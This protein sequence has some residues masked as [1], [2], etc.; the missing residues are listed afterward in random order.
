MIEDR[1]DYFIF[2]YDSPN[3]SAAAAKVPMSPQGFTKM[4]HNLERDLGVKLFESDARGVRHPTRYADVF[5]KYAKNMQD[6][7]RILNNRFTQIEHENAT[8]IRVACAVGIPGFL[9]IEKITDYHD[10]NNNVTVKFTEL[11]DTLCD[12][13]VKEGRYDLAI[14][15]QPV[16][17][18][19][20]TRNL[21]SAKYMMWVKKR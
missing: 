20:T 17:P 12:S 15:L 13:L 14:T 4:I 7:R 9:G 19:L 1:V 16:D 18:A 3:F 8:E 5:Y 2:A 10:K 11:P 6:Q 21:Y